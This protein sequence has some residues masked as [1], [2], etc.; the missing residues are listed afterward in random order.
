MC[1]LHIFII[2]ICETDMAYSFLFDTKYKPEYS[3]LE[4]MLT[5]KKPNWYH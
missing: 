4:S 3:Q 5:F 1:K 2:L